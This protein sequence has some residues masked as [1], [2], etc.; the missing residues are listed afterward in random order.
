MG[1]VM[2]DF[3]I[4]FRF[5]KL[6]DLKR[7]VEIDI[8]REQS[9]RM[10]NERMFK[11]IIPKKLVMCAVVYKQIVG[12]LYWRTQFL[13]RSNQW[14][15]EQ[16]TVDKKWRGKGVGLA[17]L[18]HFLTYA[19]NQKVEKV[20]GDVHNDNIASLKMTLAAG[21]LISGFIE[22]VGKTKQKDER[23]IIRFELK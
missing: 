1:I 22:G 7:L 23:V 3:K 10:I 16:I 2:N 12:L 6:S 15:L 21:A 5:P 9:Y 19:K 8:G 13:G 20:F 14:Y 4:T 11:E 17:L 18:G